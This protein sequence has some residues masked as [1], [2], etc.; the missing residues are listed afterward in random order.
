MAVGSV[1]RSS[2]RKPCSDRDLRVPLVPC[3][4]LWLRT[5]SLDGEGEELTHECEE[6]GR[7]C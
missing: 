6:P 3:L 5:G 1:G 4:W 2:L 7:W